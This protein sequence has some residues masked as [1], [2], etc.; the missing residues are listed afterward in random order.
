MNF[1]GTVKFNTLQYL[2]REF[3][4]QIYYY[5]GKKKVLKNQRYHT[6]WHSSD[7]I[8]KNKGWNCKDTLF[9]QKKAVQSSKPFPNSHCRVLELFQCVSWVNNQIENLS[10]IL[11]WSGKLVTHIFGIWNQSLPSYQG[12][13]PSPM[14]TS[15]H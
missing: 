1:V 8:F 13:S 14:M 6:H 15:C 2:Q 5:A 9:N 12:T 4:Y 7:R 3:Q 10:K 11:N